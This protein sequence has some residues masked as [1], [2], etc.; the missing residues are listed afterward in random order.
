MS[1]SDPMD[2]RV[3]HAIILG[4]INVD[5]FIYVDSFPEPGETVLAT[6]GDAGL[7][8]KGA[9]QAVAASL[10]G[11]KIHFI[12]Q[13]GHDS[14]ADYVREEFEA[15]G[16]EGRSLLVSDDWPTGG[17][18]ITVNN[19]GENTICVVSGANTHISPKDVEAGVERALQAA[20]GD[21][22]VALAQ[23]ETQADITS[24]FAAACAAGGARFVLNLAPFV[25]LDDKTLRLADP[26]IVNEG[27]ARM[28]L[29]AILGSYG[30]LDGVES[31]VLAA[32]ALAAT[33][34][35]S[36]IITLG[37]DGAVVAADG[38]SWHQPSPTP[39]R[40]VDTTGAGDAF[41]GSVVA[42]LARG[43]S[44]R[45]AV[46]WGVA[47]GSSAVERRGTTD[48]YPTL[49]HLNQNVLPRLELAR[50]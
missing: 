27:E 50:S 28:V 39:E 35:S 15:F 18:H 14:A 20:G 32:E 11:T 4:S 40:V 5:N 49:A 42:V 19:H 26:L 21:R 43:E 31:A 24:I 48:A 45:E 37:S 7:G 8:G 3:G 34:A 12:G 22:L 29:Q 36:V 44:L 13:V 30:Q 1:T 16:I 33:V 6:D 25:R 23:G 2:V 9:N 10:L 47:A 38:E 46:R 41:V 17:A